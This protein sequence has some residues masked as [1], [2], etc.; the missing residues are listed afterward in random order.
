VRD[1]S[2][3]ERALRSAEQWLTDRRT[4]WERRLDRLGAVLDEQVQ[5]DIP[6]P[7]R[8]RGPMP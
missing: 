3:N 7:T 8:K 2:V 4:V 6:P 5:R 1:C